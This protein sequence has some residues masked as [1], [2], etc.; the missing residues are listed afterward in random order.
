MD[1]DHYVAYARKKYCWLSAELLTRYLYNYGANTEL[2]LGSC[3]NMHFMGKRYGAELYQV[4]L[5]YLVKYE[6]AQN[7][8]D[9]LFRR[10]KLG[11]SMSNE[12][13]NELADFLSSNQLDL[14]TF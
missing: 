10:T 12:S 5:D 8:E 11:L 4:E 9:V 14:K 2:F 3:T 6:W 7:S 13:K 1:F